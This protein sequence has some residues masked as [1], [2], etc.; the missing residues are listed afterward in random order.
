MKTVNILN[1]LKNKHNFSIRKFD[2]VSISN[3]VFQETKEEEREREHL[4]ISF[5]KA[6]S[7]AVPSAKS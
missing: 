7:R 5:C 2:R 3:F 1:N 6:M 4:L